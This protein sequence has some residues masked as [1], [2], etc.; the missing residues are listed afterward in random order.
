LGARFVWHTHFSADVER[1]KA[2]YTGLFG[3][4]VQTWDM[5]G[6]FTYDAFVNGQQPLGGAVPQ[7]PAMGPAAYWLSYLETPGGVDEA[8]A[9]MAGLGATVMA[10]PFDIPTVGRMAV[11]SDPQGAVFCPYQPESEAVPRAPAGPVKGGVTWHELMTP[12]PEA[13][14]SFYGAA[15]GLTSSVMDV[16]TGPYTLLQDGEE[17]VAGIM[18]MPEGMTHPAWA[19]V[20][21]IAQDAIEAALAEVKRLGG[22]VGMG[23]VTVP[24]VGKVAA[25]QDPTGAWFHLIESEMPG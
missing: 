15:G 2:F 19:I 25:I 18:S 21:E 9:K 22:Q 7:D 8:V 14:A 4:T 12:D 10:E 17:Y 23:P 24:T 13:A 1:A 16:G 3:W 5:G 11:V 20:F 6:G